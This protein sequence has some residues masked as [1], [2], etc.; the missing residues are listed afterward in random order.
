[1]KPF[2]LRVVAAL[3]D[4]ALLR[5]ADFFVAGAADLL[6]AAF[7]L[8]A[9]RVPDFP[10][11]LVLAAGRPLR[12]AAVADF[13]TEPDWVALP[14]RLADFFAAGFLVAAAFLR[15]VELRAAVFFRA[16]AD[17]VRLVAFFAA[18]FAGFFLAAL[19]LAADLGAARLRA[20]V[21]V[22]AAACRLPAA[23][24]RAVFFF[25]DFA[26]ADFPAAFEPAAAFFRAG[27]FFVALRVAIQVSLSWNLVEP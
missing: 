7:L 19:L 18:F 9:P 11:E 24:L 13:R 17:D 26:A 14:R 20:V 21:F 10:A 16:A 8:E 4:E 23:A 22:P 1:M 25:A 15:E 12:V 27:V 3:R 2:F 6:P 5:V